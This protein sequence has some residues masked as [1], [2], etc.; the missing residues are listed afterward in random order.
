M[1]WSAFL[2]GR[3]PQPQVEPTIILL[4]C[5]P[6]D[7]KWAYTGNPDCPVCGGSIRGRD[8]GWFCAA[9]DRSDP[10]TEAV[11]ASARRFTKDRVRPEKK[12]TKYHAPSSKP[13]KSR[14]VRRQELYSYLRAG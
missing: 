3:D 8:L 5:R 6:F 13:K 1:S 2:S 12:P 4:G 9:C 11:L 10:S 14:H 7:C